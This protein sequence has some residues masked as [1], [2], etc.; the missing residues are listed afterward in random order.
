MYV[1]GDERKRPVAGRADH[2]R[3]A[4]LAEIPDRQDGPLEGSEAFPR[5]SERET[6]RQMLGRIDA[7]TQARVHAS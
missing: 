1:A 7:G 5:R 6:S 3:H 2:D 4:V